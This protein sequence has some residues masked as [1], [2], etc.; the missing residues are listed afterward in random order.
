MRVD[1]RRRDDV[2]IVDLEGRL[3]AG[4][5]DELL[6]EVLDELLGEGWNKILLNL[7]GVT[8]MDSSGI[9]EVVAGWKLARRVGGQLK[10]LR[11]GER[12]EQTLKLTQILPL[13]EVFADEERAV[14]SF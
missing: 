6:R 9:G 8:L 1:V 14:A 2:V 11:P 12:V 5:G 13:V 3:V 4:V 7:E 10:L